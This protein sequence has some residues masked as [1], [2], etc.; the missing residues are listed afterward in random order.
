MLY[1]YMVQVPVHALLVQRQV[2]GGG[3]PNQCWACTQASHARDF[4]LVHA[5]KSFQEWN[6][7]FSG[8]WGPG[9]QGPWGPG[10]QGPWGPET[11]GPKLACTM[12]YSG[13]HIHITLSTESYLPEILSISD[14]F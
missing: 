1:V 8:P 3:A 5:H 9:T 13:Q 11:Q 6:T 2:Q 7:I 14:Y 12:L 4:C 10:T